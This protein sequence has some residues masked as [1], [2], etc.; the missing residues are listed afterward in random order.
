MRTTRSVGAQLTALQRQIHPHFLFNT[1]HAITALLHQHP[2]TAEAMIEREPVT[3]VC[4]QKGWIRALR[5]H[6]QPSDDIKYKDGDGPAFW[7]HASTTDKLMLFGTNGR[8]YTIGCDKLPGGRGHGEPVRLMVDLEEN[9]AFVEIFVHEPGRRL[10]V[11]ATSGH[12]FVVPEDE[13]IAM[14]RKGKQVMNLD[15]PADDVAHA[16]LAHP[17]RCRSSGTLRRCAH[18]TGIIFVCELGRGVLNGPFRAGMAE[19]PTL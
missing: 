13:M 14:T 16:E 15:E 9:H 18:S 8:F 12:G 10:V 3:V 4:S 6:L 19:Q 2:D 1:L 11:A 17:S 5:G 7:I